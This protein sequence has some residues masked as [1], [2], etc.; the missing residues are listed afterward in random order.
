LQD[1]DFLTKLFHVFDETIFGLGLCFELLPDYI[2]FDVGGSPKDAREFRI[3]HIGGFQI[4]DLLLSLF[5]TSQNFEYVK[6]SHDVLLLGLLLELI[7]T[8]SF[9]V[10]ELQ[11]LVGLNLLSFNFI[12]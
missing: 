3:V 9:C 5:Q 12:S 10:F 11:K 1:V 8:L 4:F 2:N 6:G 7:Q